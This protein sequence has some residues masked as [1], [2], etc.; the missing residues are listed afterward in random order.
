MTLIV[1][2]GTAQKMIP[3]SEDPLESIVSDGLRLGDAP[4]P[5]SGQYVQIKRPTSQSRFAAR[6]EQEDQP[7]QSRPP[8]AGGNLSSGPYYAGD[9]R[10]PAR[11]I[12]IPEGEPFRSTQY[13]YTDFG[14]RIP[15]GAVI[16]GL[17]VRIARSALGAPL[18]EDTAEIVACEYVPITSYLFDGIVPAAEAPYVSANEVRRW[19]GGEVSTVFTEA[20]SAP[21]RRWELVANED[22][23]V[24]I[25]TDAVSDTGGLRSVDGGTSWTAFTDPNGTSTDTRPVWTGQQ[26]AIQS[27]SDFKL[28]TS[29]DGASW[30]EGAALQA[31]GYNPI[32]IGG[33]SHSVTTMSAYAIQSVGDNLYAVGVP[34]DQGS[35]ANNTSIYIS[36]N[37]GATWIASEL[38]V[39]GAEDSLNGLASSG[40]S[41]IVGGATHGRLYRTPDLDT[42][43]SWTDIGSSDHLAPVAFGNGRYVVKSRNTGWDAAVAWSGDDGV[44]WTKVEFAGEIREIVFKRGL[45]HVLT[46]NFDGPEVVNQVY[47]SPTGADWTLAASL[48]NEGGQVYSRGFTVV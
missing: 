39:G 42:S 3:G 2:P 40:S 24:V 12:Q 19:S 1:Q 9:P 14:F 10:T 18:V 25:A 26:F 45:F 30:T 31:A 41:I 7:V 32:L 8:A 16:R 5:H 37:G 47:T 48:D 22:G 20:Y 29:V 4:T 33:Q 44:S 35:Y 13:A 6:N 34:Y 43:P 11:T 46:V 15:T 38:N 28:H 21:G 36:A 23:T 27:F 17:E